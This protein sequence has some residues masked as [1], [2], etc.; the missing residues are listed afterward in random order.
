[1]IKCCRPIIIA[2]SRGLATKT[3]ESRIVVAKSTSFIQTKSPFKDHASRTQKILDYFGFGQAGRLVLSKATIFHYQACSDKIDIPIF[4]EKW[5]LEDTFFS[6]FL[7]L[8]IHV[9]MCQV[10][11]MQFG[12]EGRILRN[13]ILE[14]MWQDIDERI[15]GLEAMTS[16]QR[17][18]L[19]EDLLQHHQG[20]MLSYDEGL[21]LDDKTLAN[22]IWR[23]LFSKDPNVD[24]E[25]L[26][27]CV[28]YVRTQ[29]S[30]LRQ[31]GPHQWCLNGR[32]DWAEMPG[33][34]FNKF[35]D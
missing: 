35:I 2:A 29:M 33:Y 23:T 32:F 13:E 17:R 14:R 9:W 26:A 18:S 11:S 4:F 28:E 21:L 24:P 27:S 31:I 16:K 34:R 6:F 15:R 12:P 8:Q 20:A 7:V 19:L 30:H 25:I 3:N 5:K 10:Q 1:M 22:A